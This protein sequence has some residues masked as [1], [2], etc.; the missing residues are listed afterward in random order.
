VDKDIELIGYYGLYCDDCIRYRSRASDLARELLCELQNTEFGR[1][2]AIKS[3]S[4]DQLDAVKEFEHYG[5]GNNDLFQPLIFAAGT[6]LR[7]V[8]AAR[9]RYAHSINDS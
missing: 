4:V 7:V 6:R 1:Y 5:N 2:A 9:Y 8:R 3:S